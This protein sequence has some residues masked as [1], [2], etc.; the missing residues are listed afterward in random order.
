VEALETLAL[1]PGTRNPKPGLSDKALAKPE[2][3]NQNSRNAE[4]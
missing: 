4:L 3:R 2:T 1:R